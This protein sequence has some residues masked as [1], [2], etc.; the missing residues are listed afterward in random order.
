MDKK[1]LVII[2]IIII[3]AIFLTN[4]NLNDNN[5]KIAAVHKSTFEIPE[6]YSI[7][8][9]HSDHEV[10]IDNGTNKLVIIQMLKSS[11]LQDT[12]NQYNDGLNNSITTQSLKTPNGI[13]LTKT[14][15]T[16]DNKTY[17]RYYFEKSGGIFHIDTQNEV[18]GTDKVATQIIDSINV[19]K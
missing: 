14:S 8:D 4:L 2:I 16:I 18:D 1:Y 6:T 9:D 19:S 3:F 7:T 11:N 5:D 12:V 15:V 17:V 13:D 10:E